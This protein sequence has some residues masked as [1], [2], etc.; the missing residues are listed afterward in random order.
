MKI[1]SAT[2]GRLLSTFRGHIN[3]ITDLAVNYENTL[4]AAGSCDKMIRVW[5]LKTTSPIC[6]LTGHTGQITSLKFCPLSKDD[7]R[8]LVSTANDGCV[9]FWKWNAKT[10]EFNPKPIKYVERTRPGNNC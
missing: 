4:I 2:D 7:N 8:Y 5:C 10:R 6:V 3:E 1:W 9:C